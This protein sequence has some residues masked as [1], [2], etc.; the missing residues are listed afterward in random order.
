[1]ALVAA[2][3]TL[4]PALAAA[5]P[6]D[7]RD[8]T[9]DYLE[10]PYSVAQLRRAMVA[11]LE[12]VM[13]VESPIAGTFSR[14]MVVEQAG[15]E[16]VSMRESTLEEEFRNRMPDTNVD[17]SWDQLRDH[18]CF[19]SAQTERSRVTA[20]TPFGELAAWRYQVDQDSV[21]LVLTFADA[22]PGLPIAYERYEAGILVLSSTQAERSDRAR[23]AP[24]P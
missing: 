20:E 4:A 18:A 14:R 11:G 8:A 5:E 9:V 6:C 17:A 16:G 24:T 7:T 19:P 12:V 2:A 15:A 21:R 3:T 13:R 23:T 1:M 22:M 10:P